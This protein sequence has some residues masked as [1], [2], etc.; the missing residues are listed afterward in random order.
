MRRVTWA[1]QRHQ[2]I[3]GE[4]DFHIKSVMAR[5]VQETQTSIQ[6]WCFMRIAAAVHHARNRRIIY[7]LWHKQRCH[8]HTA[9]I[10]GAWRSFA[11]ECRFARAHLRKKFTFDLRQVC[12]HYFLLWSQAV[13]TARDF[14][15]KAEMKRRFNLLR[16]QTHHWHVR[17]VSRASYA[18]SHSRQTTASLLRCLARCLREWISCTKQAVNI[19]RCTRRLSSFCQML[20]LRRMFHSWHLVLKRLH[21]SRLNHQIVVQDQAAA[22]YAVCIARFWTKSY[23][24]QCFRNWAVLSKSISS[25]NCSSVRHSAVK[26]LHLLFLTWLNVVDYCRKRRLSCSLLIIRRKHLLQRL[27]YYAWAVSARRAAHARR[28]LEALCVRWQGSFLVRRMYAIIANW[29]SHV[30]SRRLSRFKLQ[31]ALHRLFIHER[32]L[33]RCAMNIWQSFTLAAAQKQHRSSVGQF[34]RQRNIQAFVRR[35]LSKWLQDSK[36]RRQMR[37]LMTALNRACDRLLLS[38][39]L[40]SLRSNFTKWRQ[41]SVQSRARRACCVRVE[42]I[43]QVRCIFKIAVFRVILVRI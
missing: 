6:R 17:A 29:R 18:A 26:K 12:A 1:P 39:N 33:K 9:A 32:V 36:L 2:F 7:D 20:L 5:W 8:Q 42:L 11:L 24:L 23:V 38:K 40:D 19:R 25:R 43:V 15:S 27:V 35:L 10:T 31:R 34:M 13:R 14:Q 16:A 22:N 4:S 30:R 41:Q 28:W 37:I 3:L 21:L